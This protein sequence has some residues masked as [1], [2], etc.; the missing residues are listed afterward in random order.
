MFDSN[1]LIICICS[2]YD[3][4]FDKLTAPALGFWICNQIVFSF[5]SFGGKMLSSLLIRNLQLFCCVN[6]RCIPYKIE[7]YVADQD[8]NVEIRLCVLMIA[9]PNR[10]DLVFPKVCICLPS[11]VFYFLLFYFILY[12]LMLNYAVYVILYNLWR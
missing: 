7:K 1:K 5:S 4:C 12:F 9:T 3:T 10:D 2:H 6:I 11:H 8:G